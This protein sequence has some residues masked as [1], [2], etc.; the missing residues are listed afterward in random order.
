MLPSHGANPQLLFQQLKIPMPADVI[1]FSENVNFAGLPFGIKEQWGN[2]LPL[3]EKYP[4]PLGEPFLSAISAHHDVQKEHVFVSNG[5][6]EIFSLLATIWAKKKVILIHP[7]FSEYEATLKEQQ[8]D[9]IHLQTVDIENWTLPMQRIRNQMAKAQAIY[10]CTP[11]NPTGV[12]PPKNQL[13]EII[14]LSD[15]YA[16]YVVLD[17]AFI[18]WIGEEHSFIS[19]VQAHPYLII[20]RSMTKMYSL[21]GIRLGYAI[22]STQMIERLQ[23]LASHWHVNALAA[24]IGVQCLQQKEY[25]DATVIHA[26]QQRQKFEKVLHRFGC[27]TTNSLTN[28]ICFQLPQPEKSRDFYLDMLLRGMVIRH[29]ENYRGLDGQWFRIGIK[30]SEKMQRLEQEMGA[31]FERNGAL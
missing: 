12:L 9:I 8:A 18:D 6:A 23:A 7:T 24:E 1:D 4:H 14:Q 22:A 17:E 31:W 29:T 16:C 30:T 25:K 20:S 15:R 28:Y 11:N 26:K 13:E 2:L 27:K 10:L 3:I 5:A 19:Y 21:A